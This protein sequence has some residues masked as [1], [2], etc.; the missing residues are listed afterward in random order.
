MKIFI[1][2]FLLILS[3]S[4]SANTTKNSILDNN[5]GWLHGNC[6]AIKND[7]IN[8]PLNITLV[9]LE[10]NNHLEKAK[11]T[12]KTN[13]Q[14]KCFPLFEDRKNVNLANGYS[15]YLIDSATPVDLAIGVIDLEKINVLD[16]SYCATTEGLKYFFKNAS[17]TLWE[18]YYYLGYD[19]EVTCA[20]KGGRVIDRI[21]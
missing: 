19:S 7:S 20:I 3:T 9:R 18:G 14:D 10:D 17:T 6:L 13:N 12:S 16:F 1:T 4:C 5:I 15:F 11:I 2:I 8:T 21:E